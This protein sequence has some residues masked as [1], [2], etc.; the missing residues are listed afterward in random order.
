MTQPIQTTPDGV[1]PPPQ[2][3][4]PSR[5]RLFISNSSES[6][7]MFE[8]NWMEALSK[9]HW[10]VPLFVYIPA[11]VALVW[12]AAAIK[13]TG[14]GTI[15]LWFVLGTA[16]W[17][18]VEYVLH[19]FIFHYHPKSAWGQSLHFVMHGVHHDYPSDARRLVMPP[20]ASIPIVLLMYGL[21]YLLIPAHTEVFMAGL[22]S[23]YVVY[24]MIHYALHHASFSSG[25]LKMLKQHHMRH[26]YSDPNNGF[27]VSSRIWDSV[28]GTRFETPRGR[29]NP[30]GNSG[31]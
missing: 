7:R 6:V 27:G 16:A 17:T 10:S 22:L 29:N 28:M 14:A 2:G 5:S 15:V 13:Q 3:P 23:G 31:I 4:A 25:W 26:H 18:A 12:Y 30:S 1:Q 9:V 19:R 21:F 24:D 20:T 11:I 8:R